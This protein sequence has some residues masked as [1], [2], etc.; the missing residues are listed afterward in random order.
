M[1]TTA[2]QGYNQPFGT[3]LFDAEVE[4]VEALLGIRTTSK[5]C[6]PQRVEL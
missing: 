5:I 2:Y 1:T 4:A 3:D 6:H